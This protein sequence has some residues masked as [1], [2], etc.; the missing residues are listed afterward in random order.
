MIVRGSIPFRTDHSLGVN[1]CFTHNQHDSDACA[2][3]V[4]CCG[5]AHADDSPS[6]LILDTNA[7]HRAGSRCV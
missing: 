6:P 5:D 7:R 1:D 2:I 3:P 4:Q